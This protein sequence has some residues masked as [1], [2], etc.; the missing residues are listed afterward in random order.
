MF[1]RN[2]IDANLHL[3]D[4]PRNALISD[5]FAMLLS[6]ALEPYDRAARTIESAAALD[7]ALYNRH[8]NRV[9]LAYG[10][11]VTPVPGDMPQSAIRYGGRNGRASDALAEVLAVRSSLLA[12]AGATYVSPAEVREPVE[13]LMRHADDLACRCACA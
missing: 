1:V 9:M 12:A 3:L 5:A 2:R 10:I 4:Q 7:R 13:S 8:L 6:G 11:H